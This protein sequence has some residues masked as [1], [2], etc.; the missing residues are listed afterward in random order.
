MRTQDPGFGPPSKARIAIFVGLCWLYACIHLDR[1]ILGI[2]AQSVKSDLGLS[3]QQLGALTAS[4]FSIV[5]ALLGLYF[6]RIADTADR[7]RLVCVGA[8]VWSLTCLAAAFAP[9]YDWLIASRGGVALGE[10]IATAAAI[11]LMAE[12]AGERYRARATGMFVTG[13]FVG[14]GAAAIL[15]GAILG[16][17]RNPGDWTGWRIALLAAGTPGIFGAVYLGTFRLPPSLRSRPPGSRIGVGLPV[18][19]FGASACTI[20][21]QMNLPPTQSVPLST[22]LALVI[23]AGWARYLRRSDAQAYRATLG[24]RAFRWLLVSCAAVLFVDFAASF[25]MIPYAQR[26]FGVSPASAGTQLGGLMIV[27]GIAGTLLGGWM[28]DRWRRSHPSGRV[29]TALAALVLETLAVLAALAQP[30]YGAFTAAFTAFCL[31]SGAWTALSAAVA[32][33]IVPPEYRGTGT[34]AYFLVTTLL[35]P[36]LGPFVVGL[37]SDVLGSLAQALAW[38]CA[39]S[40]IAVAGLF[41]V[42]RWLPT[43]TRQ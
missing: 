27:G 19:A 18:A 2:L 40:L 29:W 26:Q 12:L 25:W 14:A 8:W 13:A 43:A 36:G 33:D 31:A 9:G 16:H 15:G 7:L 32:V 17:F 24:Q 5:Y 42:A 30:N 39:A 37:G 41:G 28:A 20:L 22:A 23:A 3:D 10:A 21:M 6:G 4:A 35:G 34:A 11:S 38:G 1:Q